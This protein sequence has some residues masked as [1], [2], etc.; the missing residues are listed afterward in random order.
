MGLYY[1]LL[2]GLYCILTASIAGTLELRLIRPSECVQLA[3]VLCHCHAEDGDVFASQLPHS[4]KK[5]FLILGPGVGLG[6]AI[7][8][9]DCY[10]LHSSL[11]IASRRLLIV[12]ERSSILLTLY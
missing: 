11:L 4:H 6:V 7:C 3:L 2:S 5:L 12:K 10:V 8:C 9:R 1:V